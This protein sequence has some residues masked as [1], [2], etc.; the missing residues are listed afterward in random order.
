MSDN[1]GSGLFTGLVAG[2]AVSTVLMAPFYFI[3]RFGLQ[4]FLFALANLATIFAIFSPGLRVAAQDMQYCG[5][6]C[7]GA[8]I[9]QLLAEL[10]TAGWWW[11]AA[12]AW[13]VFGVSWLVAPGEIS[14]DPE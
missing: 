3:S 4:A 9:A 6:P 1:N 5:Y 8:E 12:A 10:G 14:A 2:A 7:P 13:V 11:I